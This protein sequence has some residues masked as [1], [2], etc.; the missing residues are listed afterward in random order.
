MRRNVSI[1]EVSLTSEIADVETDRSIGLGTV[2]ISISSVGAEGVEACSQ[3]AI[4]AHGPL[5]EQ[6]W[7]C[8]G[9]LCVS[10]TRN[11]VNKRIHI[12]GKPLQH[13]HKYNIKPINSITWKVQNY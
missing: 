7:P 3:E 13:T 12:C 6:V 9:V 8:V 4:R 5:H 11:Q 2:D 10:D 1:V